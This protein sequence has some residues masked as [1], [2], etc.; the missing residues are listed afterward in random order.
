MLQTISFDK[1]ALVIGGAGECQCG[2]STPLSHADQLQNGNG[3]IAPKRP[4]RSHAD[5]LARGNGGI[6]PRLPPLSHAG[7]LARGN[8]GIAPKF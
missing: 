6:V 4:Q 8:G 7:E 5:E 2:S 3:G 1:L